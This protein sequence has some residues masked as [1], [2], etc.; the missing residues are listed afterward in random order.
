[1]NR[2]HYKT[3]D[4]TEQFAHESS[5]AIHYNK[6]SGSEELKLLAAGCHFWFLADPPVQWS[7]VTFKTQGR[8]FSRRF[9]NV[10]DPE[11][12]SK[13]RDAVVLEVTRVSIQT[14]HG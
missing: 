3:I 5:T 8:G 10:R 13:A 4:S 9:A 7:W 6:K 14:H 11:L 12:K 1:M 2:E